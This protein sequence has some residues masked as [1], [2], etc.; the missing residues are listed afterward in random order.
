MLTYVINTSDNK[1]FDSRML[2]ELAG[3]SKIR[4]LHCP[5]SDVTK[6]AEHICERQNVVG[7]ERFRVAVIV[8]FYSFNK[9]R[10]PYGRDSF[11]EEEYV[12]LSLYIPYIEVFLLDN[13]VSEF[14]KSN[15]YA[16]DVEIF[17]VQNEKSDRYDLFKN[18]KRQLQ[19][20]EVLTGVVDEQT[21]LISTEQP[22]DEKETEEKS[23]G[24]K[25]EEKSK[26]KKTEEKSKAEKVETEE[27]MP[28]FDEKPADP[29]WSYSEDEGFVPNENNSKY[30]YREFM[31]YCTPNVSLRFRLADYPYGKDE[32]TFSEFRDAFRSR[33]S[34]VSGLRRHFYVVPYGGG[35]ARAA[36]AMLSLSLYLIRMYEREESIPSDGDMDMLYLDPVLLRDVLETAW[37]KV[38]VAKGVVKKSSMEYYSLA[39]GMTDD[40]VQKLPETPAEIQRAKQEA[41]QQERV[42]L[43]AEAGK[44]NYSTEQYY[45][46]V[47]DMAEPG[48]T[49]LEKSKQDEFDSIM[50]TYLRTR[51]A[52]KEA[53]VRAEFEEMKRGGFLKMTDQCPSREEYNHFVEKK[54]KDISVLFEKALRA[55]YIEVDYTEEK[56]R[57]NRVYLAYRRAKACMSRNIIGDVFFFLLSL[58]SVLAP[59]WFLQLNLGSSQ[60]ASSFLLLLQNAGFFGGLFLI[61]MALRYIPLVRALKRAK[62]EMRKCYFE[63]TVKRN[64]S[65]SALRTRYEKDLVAIEHARYDLRQLK[66]L[67]D[68]NHEKEKLITAHREML[69]RL[70]DCLG[71]ILNNLDVEPVPD[72]LLSV[73]D[74]LN[75]ARPVSSKENK[76]YQV[77]SVETIERMLPMKGSD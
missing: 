37:N 15:L 32:M 40:A 26:G 50:A 61:A 17:Y 31:L 1:T 47:M 57:A 67:H 9:I 77:F 35:S 18:A 70:E 11:R 4:W 60:M 63:C 48:S 46:R 21:R 23:E 44:H 53:D 42:K 64:Y 38:T 68:A 19:N 28:E 45:S 2:F 7:A 20:A 34:Y 76:I 6:V 65:F 69:E 56:E 24:K 29:S 73:D 22:A 30:L 59:Y 41:M 8:D 10:R 16:E 14:E 71:G 58:A 75:L 3:Y 54:Q 5:L 43:A 39:Q 49:H 12:D 33:Q 62:R 55:D 25:T 36:L 66:Y 27:P 74:E 13:M 52:T 72:P 51:D